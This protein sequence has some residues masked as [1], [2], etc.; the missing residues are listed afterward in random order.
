MKLIGACGI[1]L[2]LT[3]VVREDDSVAPA[4]VILTG[5]Q[6][7][8]RSAADGV[9]RNRRLRRAQLRQYANERPPRR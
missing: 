5:G 8:P 3:P 1:D 2:V 9:A 6:A 7:F 4:R